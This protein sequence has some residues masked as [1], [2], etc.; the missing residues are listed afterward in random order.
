FGTPPKC[1]VGARLRLQSSML[2]LC[3]VFGASVRGEGQGL[4]IPD[5]PKG[6]VI[7]FSELAAREASFYGPRPNSLAAEPVK[8]LGPRMPKPKLDVPKEPLRKNPTGWSRS[9]RIAPVPS[10][11]VRSNGAL[12]AEAAPVTA[13]QSAQIASPSSG[14]PPSP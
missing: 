11:V 10:K 7:N 1:S 12:T 3:V 5:D 9:P 2:L 13:S 14:N 4:Q 8:P 6:D